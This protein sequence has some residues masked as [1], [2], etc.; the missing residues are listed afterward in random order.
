MKRN[1]NKITFLLLWKMGL[2]IQINIVAYTFSLEK[3]SELKLQ[4][5]F[6]TQEIPRLIL[7]SNQAK[8]IPFS[9]S[10]SF[11]LWLA[12]GCLV[13]VDMSKGETLHPELCFLTPEYCH[14]SS[15]FAS[16]WAM[17]EITRREPEGRVQNNPKAGSKAVLWKQW[18]STPS[19]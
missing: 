6:N 19:P 4:F 1:K 3:W 11:D 7:Q 9:S 14:V 13:A 2:R 18:C 17:S 15:S 5:N 12:E 10:L 8:P 16:Q